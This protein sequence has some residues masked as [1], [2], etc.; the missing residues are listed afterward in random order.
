MS[1]AIISRHASARSHG[2][3]QLTRIHTAP[4]PAMPAP[5]LQH[6]IFFSLLAHFSSPAPRIK[7]S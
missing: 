6:C 2:A 5:R 4:V 7:T 3:I 1:E